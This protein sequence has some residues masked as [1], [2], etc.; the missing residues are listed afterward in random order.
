MESDSKR[1]QA[2]ANNVWVFMPWLCPVMVQFFGPC[3]VSL[4]LE[5]FG[6]KASGVTGQVLGCLLRFS[7]SRN[8]GLAGRTDGA[9][10]CCRAHP[11]LGSARDT[12]VE[13]NYIQCV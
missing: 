5:R 6:L 13:C 12:A 1:E 3:T 10:M 4:R 11:E 9:G 8:A 7:G 2:A